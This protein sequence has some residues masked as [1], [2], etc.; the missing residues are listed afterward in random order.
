MASRGACYNIAMIQFN[1]SAPGDAY[2]ALKNQIDSRYPTGR[3]V[4]IDGARVIADAESHDKLVANL[5]AQG[6]SPQ[7]LII[8][9]AGVHYPTAATIFCGRLHA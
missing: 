7:N 6:R 1:D 9:Q 2:A 3:Y 4:A 5:R 8:V